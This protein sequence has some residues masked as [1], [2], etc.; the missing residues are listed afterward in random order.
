MKML[1]MTL[2]CYIGDFTCSYI[3]PVITIIVHKNS[4]WKLL[5]VKHMQR[6]KLSNTQW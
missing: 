1:V 6:K 2:F 4:A 3:I 5:Y